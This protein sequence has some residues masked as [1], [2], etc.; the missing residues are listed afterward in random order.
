MR[1]IRWAALAIL[2]TA[3]PLAGQDTPDVEVELT[4]RL[5]SQFHTSTVDGAA[6]TFDLRRVRIA[7][8]VSIGEAM[9]GAIE[10]EYA[11]GSLK[12]RQAWLEYDV[13]S[14]MTL[15][16]GQFKK[17]FGL[18]QLTSSL[19]IPVI[20]RGLRIRGIAG[21]Y[22]EQDEAA[23]APV[24]TDAGG[25]LLGEHQWLLDALGYQNYDIGAGVHGGI[26]G[27][28]YDAGV[29]NGTGA[30]DLDADD[31]KALA[32]RLS[33][34]MLDALSIGVA[35]SRTNL[36]DGEFDADGVAFEID[37][38]WGGF[39]KQGPHLLAEFAFGDN[40]AADDDFM[41]GQAILAYFAP[42]SAGGVE[43]VE[44]VLR[45]GW[46]DP[47][48]DRDEDA[49]T[50]VTPGFNVY[51]HGRNRLMVNWDVFVPQGDRF[52]TEHSFKVQA[53]LHF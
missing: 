8:E 51:F 24:L 27:L 38:E 29:F 40:V 33:Y 3:T 42:V 13:A 47:A 32:A 16:A 4:G 37:A 15:R 19:A 25:P 7:A 49:G 14:W 53:Q 50:L 22:A 30:D 35:V 36:A 11:L 44:P 39:R 1:H 52:S 46:G 20:E 2:V 26:G 9:R 21:S 31:G 41:A 45:G 10:P 18:I 48:G 6:S 34:A 5:Q 17:P 43:G 28:S 12:L 23:G